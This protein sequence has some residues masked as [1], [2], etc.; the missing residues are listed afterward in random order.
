MLKQPSRSCAKLSAPHCITIAPG[1][2][3]SMT[4]AH[5]QGC[6]A[7][8]ARGVGRAQPGGCGVCTARGVGRAQPKGVGCTQPGVWGA[9][10]QG[11]GVRTARHLNCICVVPS[12]VPG[13]RVQV[14]AVSGVAVTR[15]VSVAQQRG[16]C[17]W[18][19]NVVPPPVPRP[20]GLP[21]AAHQ[22]SA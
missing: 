9:H 15:C 6:G 2:K 10:S 3:T 7:C 4:C 11:C 13:A 21:A 19:S 8:T 5:S 22:Y 18:R 17:L 14:Q 16:A 20:T 12:A 1:R